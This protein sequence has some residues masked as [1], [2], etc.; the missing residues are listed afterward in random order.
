MPIFVSIILYILLIAVGALCIYGQVG[1]TYKE[2]KPE[3][4]RQIG[5]IVSYFVILAGLVLFRMYILDDY[6]DKDSYKEEIQ[7][8]YEDGYYDSYEEWFSE[9]YNKGYDDGLD[10]GYD[11]GYDD[12][13]LGIPKD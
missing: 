1:L 11:I 5:V 8:A 13:L 6:H 9:G 12:A 7:E 4:L 10:S 2:E 3:K